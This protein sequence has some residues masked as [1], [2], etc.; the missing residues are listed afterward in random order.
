M[1][2]AVR[3]PDEQVRFLDSLVAEGGMRSRAEVISRTVAR[4]QRQHQ[5]LADLGKIR[6]QPY[7]EF[8][9]FHHAALASADTD[10]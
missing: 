1:Q 5:A 9:D 8:E 7:E 3:L 4:L 2:I 10:D 6:A